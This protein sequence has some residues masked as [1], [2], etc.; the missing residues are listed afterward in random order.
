MCITFQSEANDTQHLSGFN[1]V[2]FD[3][4]PFEE[5]VVVS[6][7]HCEIMRPDVNDVFSTLCLFQKESN[8]REM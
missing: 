6:T 4:Y 1:R 8:L 2:K 3:V 5:A 7:E